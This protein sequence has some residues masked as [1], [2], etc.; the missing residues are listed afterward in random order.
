RQY[1]QWFTKFCAGD[2]D[3][4]GAPRSRRLI[5]VDDDKIKALIESNPRYTIQEIAE[6]LNIHH[7]SVHD[8]LKKLGYI[9]KLDIWI[10]HELKEVYLM[11]RI[12]IYD[13]LI[14]REENDPFLKRLITGDEKWIIY[15]NVVRKRS[16]SRRDDSLQ[17]T[18]KANIHQ[19]K[20]MLLVWWDFKG[21]V[22]FE[23]LPRN[24]TINSNVLSAIGQFERI[25]HLE[26]SRGK[27]LCSII[28]T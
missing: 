17:T 12:N 2:F 3:L 15:N 19:R 10:P 13:M 28:T 7:S 14:K 5:K 16:W 1:Q 22:F 27:E 23:L 24:Q 18:S 11:A 9:S 26:T 21:V 8:H 4:N 20:V 6:T 25:H